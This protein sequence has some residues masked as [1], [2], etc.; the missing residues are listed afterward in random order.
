M[1]DH[2]NY[3]MS[4]GQNFKAPRNRNPSNLRRSS[5]K[6]AELDRASSADSAVSSIPG[7]FSRASQGSTT[8]AGE[9]RL[10]I[11]IDYGT[12]FT[13]TEYELALKIYVLTS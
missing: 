9:H 13:G 3:F 7:A 11:A 4:S 8:M 12:T 2:S 6:E 5:L 10:V 1:H